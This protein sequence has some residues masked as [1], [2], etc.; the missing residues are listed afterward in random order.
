MWDLLGAQLLTAAVVVGVILYSLRRYKAEMGALTDQLIRESNAHAA[1]LTAD[2][3]VAA[4]GRGGAEPAQPELTD[5][6]L[7]SMRRAYG[8]LLPD[9]HLAIIQRTLGQGQPVEDAGRTL[10][11]DP[12][13]SRELLTQ[14]LARLCE[15]AE[16]AEEHGFAPGRPR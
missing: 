2:L 7:L 10:G 16:V 12:G 6:T 14:A 8:E 13:E 1:R 5:L 9:D 15:F 3:A 11:R 4:G